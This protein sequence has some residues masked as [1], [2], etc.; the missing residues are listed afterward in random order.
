[1]L[2]AQLVFSSLFFLSLSV[3]TCGGDT[4]LETNIE[5]GKVINRSSI[6]K[7]SR[8]QGNL[9][10]GKRVLINWMTL[11]PGD[12]IPSETLP[13]DRLTIAWKG[14][15][16][17]WA[18]GSFK[19]LREKDCIYLEGGTEYAVCSDGN[20]ADII[21]IY[22][23]SVGLDHSHNDEKFPIGEATYA[24]VMRTWG[25]DTMLRP[26][27]SGENKQDTSSHYTPAIQ[28]GIVFSYYDLLFCKPNKY[29][30]TRIFQG[31]R[32]QACFIRM[33][34]GE[35]IQPVECS[36]EQ[37]LCVLEGMIE[38]SFG[39]STVHMGRN[40]VLHLV[41]GM[42]HSATAD[43]ESTVLAVFGSSQPVFAEVLKKQ[44][45]KFHAIIPGGSRPRLC[46]D[47]TLKKPGLTF[48]EGPCWLDGK[49]YFC[50]TLLL[51]HRLKKTD[52][53]GFNTLSS[54]GIMHVLNRAIQPVGT[55]PLSNGNIAV[56]EIF[57]HGILE[58]T[59]DGR[60]VRTIA[61]SFEGTP[62]GG[63]N[64]LVVD[65]K[66]G[67][68]FTD[69]W[70]GVLSKLPGKAVYYIT[71]SGDVKRLTEWNEYN[72]PNGCILSPD[73]SLFYLNAPP[74][75]GGKNR[76]AVWVYDVNEDGTITNKQ[77]FAEI[78]Y[79]RT[80]DGLAI[81][82]NGN[83]Y[84]ATG[85]GGIVIFDKTGG[86]IGHIHFPKQA[87]NCVF[88]GDDLSTLYVTC[89]NHIYSIQTKMQ[90]VHFPLR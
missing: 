60:V 4:G 43:S 1:M 64:D 66:G 58:L 35:T 68:Y 31:K 67:I 50:N 22:W 45:E 90:G 27:E 61:D 5:P 40:D 49:L 88:G 12:D 7:G 25:M 72:F 53:G 16:K 62:F 29:P 86:Y 63:P 81:D 8:V 47:G 38:V 65:A 71:L 17:V 52:Q 84:V 6:P 30:H 85:T 79:G 74:G 73:G 75:R 10:W 18:N 46:Y 51:T 55:M 34:Q 57:N 24:E 78:V 20:E 89:H 21:E 14:S 37:F 76:P 19:N 41:K 70:G 9:L 2:V 33:S 54:D 26:W 28:P 42:T 56:T 44:N 23:P 48:S 3:E 32:G 80:A 83:L 87:Q 77:K 82:R 36:D 11:T 39:D 69:P 13:G 59:T 15:V